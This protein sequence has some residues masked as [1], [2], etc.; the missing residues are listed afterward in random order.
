MGTQPEW[1]Q[2][3]YERS[4]SSRCWW[5]T[6][7]DEGWCHSGV[8]TDDELRQIVAMEQ[9]L[10]PLP[11]WA[12]QMAEVAIR[13]VPPCGHYLFPR[14]YLQVVAAI[15]AEDSRAPLHSYCFAVESG[16]K[17]D[18]QDYCLCLDGWLAG[19]DPQA[20]ARDLMA[21]GQRRIDWRAVCADLWQVLGAHTEMKDLLVERT[22][23]QQRWWIKSCA[24]P[25]DPA[26]FGRDQ[27]LG[28]Y[29]E[30]G[31]PGAG[32]GNPELAL[33][34]FRQDTSPRVQRVEQRL[35]EICPDW[36]WFRDVIGW[37]WPC[38]PKAFRY[39]EKLLWCIGRER[40]VISL[41]S[42]PL[43]NPEEVPGFL[44]C[45]DTWPDPDLA[46]TWWEAFLSALRGWWRGQP[47][48]GEVADEIA[49]RLG[50]RTPTKRWLVRLLVRRLEMAAAQGG[51]L[52]L[53]VHAPPDARRG[54]GQL[55]FLR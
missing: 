38:A 37:S 23:H 14:G 2:G 46:S 22:L 9:A 10:G 45:E 31:W 39:L 42:F 50:E 51:K 16:R 33:P 21:L 52:G 53:L 7:Y 36:H 30:T 20:I 49:R 6:P 1:S 48:K 43:E 26:E 5:C 8:P 47:E 35:A 27:Y 29:A 19:A 41:P 25:G 4:L 24:W 28:D 12:R 32:E 17:R 11:E 15:G 54:T 3:A 44:R 55:S 18:F 34:T 40:P 13:F